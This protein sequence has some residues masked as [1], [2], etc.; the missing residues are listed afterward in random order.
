MKK[1]LIL[2]FLYC[3][4]IEVSYGFCPEDSLLCR[5]YFRVGSSSLDLSFSE[6]SRHLDSLLSHVSTLQKQDVLHHV[7]LISS[8]SPE[9][10][11]GVN[12]TLS[13]KR[14][15]AVRS[16]LQEH[17]CLPD[18]VFVSSSL[19]Q[20]WDALACLVKDSDIPYREEA[21][22]ILHNT[23]EWIIQK[24]LVVDSRK[25]QLMTLRQG[26]PWRYMV[27]HLF[28]ELRSCSILIYKSEPVCPSFQ[29]SE[30]K[31]VQ[32]TEPVVPYDTIAAPPSLHDTV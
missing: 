29:E 32:V 31:E 4:F 11:S 1:Y 6:N 8:A 15:N 18:S 14:C 13:D 25:R 3:C 28:P 26:D 24:N 23:P 27:A 16:Y 9:G 12:L 10:D 7:S 2:I 20:A 30:R 21:L 5:V 19:G 17:L 22:H